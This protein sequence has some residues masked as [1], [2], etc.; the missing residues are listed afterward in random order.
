MRLLLQ[1]LVDLD[2]SEP[3]LFYFAPSLSSRY[4]QFEKMD[5]AALSTAVGQH[6]IIGRMLK[7]I[8]Y[9]AD[10]QVCKL[11]IMNPKICNFE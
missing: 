10:I 11:L 9:V 5:Q 4:N 3:S 1:M 7:W 6:Y 8:E 2:P